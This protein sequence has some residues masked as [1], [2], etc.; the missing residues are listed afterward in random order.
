MRLCA[1]GGN[2]VSMTH[3][4]PHKPP[5]EDLRGY[6]QSQSWDPILL[7]CLVISKLRN[8]YVRI[9][10]CHRMSL[11]WLGVIKQYKLCVCV[12]VC[13]CVWERERERE[14]ES[15]SSRQPAF[16]FCC[17]SEQMTSSQN[18]WAGGKWML[19]YSSRSLQQTLTCWSTWPSG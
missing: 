6:L 15:L 17:R 14:R 19:A 13:V 4:H 3:T 11:P 1:L 8:E 12:R 2:R 16:V 9:H 7:V 18:Q 5:R 10:T